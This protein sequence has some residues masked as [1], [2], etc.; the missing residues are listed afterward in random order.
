MRSG[1]VAPKLAV[2]QVPGMLLR[3]CARRPWTAPGPAVPPDSGNH[4]QAG[5][6]RTCRQ[7]PDGAAHQSDA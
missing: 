1:W 4:R 7:R 2:R 5:A 3:H 6:R